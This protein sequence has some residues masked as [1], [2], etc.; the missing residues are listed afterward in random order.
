MLRSFGAK[1]F[2]IRQ[3]THHPKLGHLF[4]AQLPSLPYRT[5][6]RCFL[7]LAV[8]GLDETHCCFTWPCN[9]R[10][11]RG[12]SHILG[13]PSHPMP[14]LNPELFEIWET[15]WEANIQILVE[16]SVIQRGW[17]FLPPHPAIGLAWVFSIQKKSYFQGAPGSFLVIRVRFLGKH[18]LSWEDFLPMSTGLPHFCRF[19]AHLNEF[20]PF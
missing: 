15:V 19:M 4:R 1:P 18:T 12:I 14:S 11:T 16:K 17:V 2:S 7:W 5:R 9:L 6:C 8:W 13:T 10:E 20:A 3:K